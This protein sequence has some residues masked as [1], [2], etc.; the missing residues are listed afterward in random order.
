VSEPG[1]TPS[2][3]RR[4]VIAVVR[5][6][7]SPAGDLRYGEAF[8]AATEVGRRFRSWAQLGEVLRGIAATASAQ[9][10]RPAGDQKLDEVA[11]GKSTNASAQ[12]RSR[13]RRQVP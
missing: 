11:R 5:L 4:E 2:F 7:L 3:D 12:R 10:N 9:G 13:D 6:T 8:D 1:L